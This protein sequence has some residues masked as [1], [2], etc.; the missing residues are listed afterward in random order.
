MTNSVKVNHGFLRNTFNNVLFI[1]SI[2][3]Y[4]PHAW[5]A[6]RA[7]RTASFLYQSRWNILWNGLER[8]RLWEGRE[9]LGLVS[10]LTLSLHHVWTAVWTQQTYL[11]GACTEKRTPV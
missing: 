2:P 4:H 9:V 7:D 10:Q 11:Q 3:L 6:K 1:L 8:M 5:Y